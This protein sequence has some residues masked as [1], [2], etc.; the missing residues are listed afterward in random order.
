MFYWSFD[1]RTLANWFLPTPPPLFYFGSH[2]EE[3]VFVFWKS[4]DSIGL[5]EMAP[6]SDGGAKE[7][8]TWIFFAWLKQSFLLEWEVSEREREGVGNRG[9]VEH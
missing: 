7:W 1:T 5:R 4:P 9:L 3:D 6:K 8:R 2:A